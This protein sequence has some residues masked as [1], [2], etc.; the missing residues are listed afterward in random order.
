S[1]VGALTR[2]EIV[3]VF[4]EGGIS[5]TGQLMAIRKGFELMARRARVPVVPAAIDGLWGSVFSFAGK[6]YIW[7]SPRLLPTPVCIAFGEPIPHEKASARTA[8][9]AMMELWLLAFEERP[10]LRRN[11]GR[12]VIR[13]LAGRPGTVAI[14]DRS[15]G[16]RVVTGAPP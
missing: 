2:G 4:P 9:K 11:I 13:S 3:C 8:R 16:R 12:E 5:R 7:K 15:M 14:I 1:S 6:R 10:L